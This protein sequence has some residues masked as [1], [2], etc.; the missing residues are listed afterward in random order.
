MTSNI[1]RTEGGGPWRIPIPA[2][3]PEEVKEIRLRSV[4]Y[5]NRK[6]FFKP[7]LPLDTAAVKNR[8]PDNGVEVTFN[9]QFDVFVEPNAADTFTEAG[10]TSIRVKNV[11]GTAIAESDLILQVSKE[12]YDA[13]DA[14]RREV[15]KHPLSKIAGGMLG[16]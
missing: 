9:G 10:I 13:D 16:L 5:R 8:D 3:D 14:A 7:W 1:D 11:G 2:L 15:Q 12:P 6:G 4:E